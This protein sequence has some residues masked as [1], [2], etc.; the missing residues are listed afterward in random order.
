MPF[1]VSKLPRIAILSI[2]LALMDCSMANAQEHQVYMPLMF[3][4]DVCF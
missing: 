3:A 2:F 4:S 1:L